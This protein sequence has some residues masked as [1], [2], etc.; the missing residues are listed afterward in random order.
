MPKIKPFNGI[1]PNQ[2]HAGKVVVNLENLSISEAKIIRQ[3]NPYSYVNML[4]PKLDNIFLMGSKNELAFK[5]I[6]EKSVFINE[7]KCSRDEKIYFGE[8]FENKRYIAIENNCG[9]FYF[10]GWLEN[11]KE[12]EKLLNQVCV[13]FNKESNQAVP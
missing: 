3:D 4:V 7:S 10:K 6:N 2:S 8:L 9:D 13:G 12:L 1:H 5:K 11:K